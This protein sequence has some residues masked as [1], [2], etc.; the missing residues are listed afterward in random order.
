MDRRTRALPGGATRTFNG[1]A[2]GWQPPSP[3]QHVARQSQPRRPSV[4]LRLSGDLS[5]ARGERAPGCV[6][7][8]I[9]R[10]R[11]ADSELGEAKGQPSGHA[12]GSDEVN[13]EDATAVKDLAGRESGDNCH[14]RP[15]R[16]APETVPSACWER[17]RTVTGT[18]GRHRAGRGG[19]DLP[20]R[21][22]RVPRAER[23]GP[24]HRRG[25][26]GGDHR[27]VGQRQDHHHQPHRRHRP[28]H[29]PAR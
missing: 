11:P 1:L 18:A 2:W 8:V 15:G 12:G 26:D 28:A 6:R 21:A 9:A 19:E 4:A 22:D 14:P 16:A 5:L 29:A 7:S 20:Q 17:G 13:D 24:G 3:G 25:R 23:R 10:R 27:P